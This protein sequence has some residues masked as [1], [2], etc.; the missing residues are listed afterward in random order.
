MKINISQL[1]DIFAIPFFALS[2]LYFYNIPEKNEIEYILLFFSFSGF[3][4]D[5]LFTFLFLLEKKN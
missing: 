5:I 1:G 3:I 4:L 2:F